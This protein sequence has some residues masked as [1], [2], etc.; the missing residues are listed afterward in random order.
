MDELI[1][2]LKQTNI[3]LQEINTNLKIRYNKEKYYKITED[4][5]IKEF[6]DPEDVIKYIN[7]KYKTDVKMNSLKN[8]TK[9]HS[10]KTNS[11]YKKI[12]GEN[13]KFEI[14]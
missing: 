13:F 9:L 12:F 11:K 5:E 3:L 2:S 4:E 1:K 7:E 8:L 6:T 10:V 14:F